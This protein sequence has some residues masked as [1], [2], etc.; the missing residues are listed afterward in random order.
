MNEDI[1]GNNESLPEGIREALKFPSGARY[2]RCAL[3]VNPFDY[4]KVNRGENHGLN[5]EEYNDQIIRKCCELKINVIAVTDHNHVGRINPI[6]EKARDTNI[7]VFPGFE[8]ASSEGVHLLCIFD[9]NKEVS[10]LERY[11]GDLGIYT[12]TPTTENSK[13]SFHDVLYKVQKEWD[14]IC[15]AA[16]I[17]NNG[18]LLRMLQGEARINAWR[19]PNLLAV[20]IP[21]TIQDLEFPHREIVLNKNKDYRRERK[22]AVI[23]ASDIGKPSDLDSIQSSTYIKMSVPSVEG[24]RQAF[25]DPDSRIRLLTE[26]VPPEHTEII[27][28]HWEGGFLDKQSI[29]FNSNLNVLIGGRGTGKS[30]IIESIRY[31]LD[32]EP[33]GEEAKKNFSGI[34]KQVIKSGTKIS[35]LIHSHY[36][37]SKYYIIERIYPNP[38]A[39][40]DI[41]RNFLNLLPGD[42]CKNLEI[43]GQHEI[44]ELTRYPARLSRLLKRFVKE[45]PHLI[46]K[47]REILKKLEINR[48]KII[49]LQN[50][51][52][53]ISNRSERLPALEETHKRFKDAGLEERLKDQS[54]IVKE[55][56]I[57]KIAF[58]RLD[59]IKEVV[60]SLLEESHIDRAFVSDKLLE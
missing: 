19:D 2:F 9:I 31:I 42:I 41:E 21:G 40:K 33:I 34:M 22:I 4:L 58:E 35:L 14:G 51:I 44:G 50:G 29:H 1:I 27:A 49:E 36:P 15:I 18:G 45:D 48:R 6:R 55:D 39:V 24:L 3:Q 52:E 5:E 57:I 17:T 46:E 25:L 20:Q 26:D 12:A 16:H 10:M 7:T 38:P 11:L 60:D 13:E 54:Y 23:N 8:V 53:D 56:Q 28:L 43:Y 32:L 37:S 30:T 47:K 59:Q